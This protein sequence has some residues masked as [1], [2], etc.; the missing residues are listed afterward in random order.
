MEIY[1]SRAL[2]P[3]IFD[4]N[5]LILIKMTKPVTKQAKSAKSPPI[6]AVISGPSG[7]G[8]DAVIDRMKET[9]AHLH[10]VVTATTRSKRHN[11]KEGIHYHFLTKRQFKNR[12]ANNEFLEYAEVYG[13]YYG[14]LVTEVKSALQK[15]VDVII[16]VDVQGAATLKR[17]SS[18]RKPC[19]AW[20]GSVTTRII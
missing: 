6:V 4:R 19:A 12:I 11:E 7:V 20:N 15:G 5:T 1:Y 2:Q 8:K 18:T 3:F 13:N 10:Y 9:G 17:M 16:K 14:V